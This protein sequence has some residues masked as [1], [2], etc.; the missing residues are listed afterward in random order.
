MS[1][2]GKLAALVGSFITF[3]LACAAIGRPDIPL[4]LIAGLRANTSDR[5][6]ASWGC[7]SVFQKNGCHSYDSKKYR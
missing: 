2:Q 3:Y 5:T 4:H 1:F 6:K 7:P